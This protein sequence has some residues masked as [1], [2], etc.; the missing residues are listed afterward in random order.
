MSELKDR[1]K[2][3]LTAA[4]KERDKVRTGTLRMVLAAISTEES[5]GSSQR[6]LDDAEVTKLL[7][8]EAK[9]RREAAEA[10]DQGGRS[11][12]AAAERAE[13]EVIS[14]YL[15]KQLTDGELSELVSAAIGETG[16]EGPKQM[17]Q[18]MKVVNP[19]VAG[20]AE[21]SRVAAEVKRQLAG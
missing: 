17:G 6:D 9:K 2:N 1:L 19:R 7:T 14:D 4:I 21:G 3:D 20:Q 15:P 8:R 13:S 11:D 10:F 18:V 16:A 12:Q 5:A